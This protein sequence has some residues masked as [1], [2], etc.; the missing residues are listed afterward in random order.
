MEALS[1]DEEVFQVDGLDIRVLQTEV[2]ARQAFVLAP[3]L[4]KTVTEYEPNGKA[5]A[6]IRS[7][8]EE[9]GRCL[10]GSAAV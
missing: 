1:V 4:G 9:I 7:L 3:T 6:E 5:A 8:S 10:Q 2:T